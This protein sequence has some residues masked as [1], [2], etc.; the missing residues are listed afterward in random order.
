MSTEQQAEV[1]FNVGPKGIG[2]WL[3]MPI[4]GFILT[5]LF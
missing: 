4:I 1:Q 2:G 3:L 5:I